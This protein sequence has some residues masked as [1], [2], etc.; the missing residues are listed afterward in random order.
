MKRERKK[1]FL[2]FFNQLHYSIKPFPES[3]ASAGQRLFAK[4]RPENN[5]KDLSSVHLK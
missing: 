4:L 2:A 3:E 5:L 1:M